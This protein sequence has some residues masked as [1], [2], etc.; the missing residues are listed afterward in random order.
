VSTRIDATFDHH[1][2]RALAAGCF[3]VVPSGGV[4]DELLPDVLREMSFHDGTEENFTTRL[5]DAWYQDEGAEESRQH[6]AREALKRFD[7]YAACKAIDERIEQLVARSS[8]TSSR[9]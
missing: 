7:A 8:T 5:Q 3:P 1:A 4:Y 6:D 2:V 9:S